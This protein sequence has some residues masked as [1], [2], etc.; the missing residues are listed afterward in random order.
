[1]D[2]FGWSRKK[3]VGVNMVAVTLL[4][5][6]C[7][8]GFNLWSGFHPIRESW[9]V[10]DLEDFIVSYNILPLGA[11]IYVLFCVTRLGWGWQNFKAEAD[12]G[13]GIK[14]PSKARFYA[15]YILPIVIGVVFIMGYVTLFGS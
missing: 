2:M 13:E 15:T 10:L 6:P 1:M 14:F 11:L 8:L 9:G 7:A 4:S 5:I 3:A 12:A